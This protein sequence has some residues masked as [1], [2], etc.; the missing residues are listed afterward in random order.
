MLIKESKLRQI[1]K[2]VIRESIGGMPPG[3]MGM[4]PKIQAMNLLKG[5]LLNMSGGKIDMHVEQT[6]DSDGIED[7]ESYVYGSFSDLGGA[8]MYS[9]YMSDS[10]IRISLDTAVDEID[11]F[12]QSVSP[13]QIIADGGVGLASQIFDAWSNRF[14]G[15]GSETR[16]GMGNISNYEEEEDDWDYSEDD[17]DDGYDDA[18]A[19]IPEVVPPKPRYKKSS[20]YD[21]YDLERQ[22]HNKELAAW[23]SKYG[24]KK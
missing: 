15:S 21:P 19:K 11:C 17:D 24:N 10:G 14:P 13:S 1:I 4:D 9:V 2:S 20:G 18:M 22:Y 5:E 12:E 23:N 3:G 6:I 7:D 16:G 8:N